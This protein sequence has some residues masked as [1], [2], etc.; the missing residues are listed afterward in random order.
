MDNVVMEASSTYVRPV[1][2]VNPDDSSTLKCTTRRRRGGYAVSNDRP[3][4]LGSEDDGVE[5]TQMA[6]E[7]DRTG[8]GL[9]VSVTRRLETRWQ[10]SGKALT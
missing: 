6:P 2:A 10:P 8:G 1:C 7:R 4:S 3:I 5:R 9:T